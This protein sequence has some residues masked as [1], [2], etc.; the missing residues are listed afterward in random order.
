MPMNTQQFQNL[1]LKKI[2]RAFFEAYDEETE[3]W[4]Q[5]LN[6][7]SS[8]DYAEITQ[9]FAGTGRWEK[10]EELD[11]PKEQRFKL[12]DLIQTLHTPYAVQIVMSR[13][14]VDDSK[15]NEVEN[16]TRDAGHGAR[17]EVETHCAGLLDNSFTVNQYDGVPLFS[18]SHP[19]RGDGGGTQSNLATGSLTDA[20]L[21]AGLILFRKQ[22]DEAGKKINARAKKL[23]INQALQFT[24]ATIINSALT[25]GT[26]NN[27]TNPLPSLQIVDLDFTTSSTA[28]FLQ[29]ARHKLNHYWRVPVE[30]KRKSEMEDNGS[31]V[32]N[33]YFRDSTE[34]GDWRMMVGSTG[35]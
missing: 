24:A 21:K 11:N 34:V 29:G 19:N 22:R 14:Q 10:K 1:Y 4:S 33:G 9:R 26:A 15:Y 32:W 7:K 5:Y 31:W 16:M 17:E 13:E 20:N 6:D 25:S 35:L 3:Q 27:D 2:D 18:A 8:S 30:F 23:I 28:W 12:G